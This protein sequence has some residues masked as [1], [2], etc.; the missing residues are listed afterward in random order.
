[1]ADTHDHCTADKYGLSSDLVNVDDGWNRRK[2]H[3]VV[4]ESCC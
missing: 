4:I 3:A 1:V 2:E